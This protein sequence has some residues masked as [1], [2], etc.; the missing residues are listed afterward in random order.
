VKIQEILWIDGDRQLDY[1]E[2]Q[3]SEI[4]AQV[5]GRGIRVVL[6]V[7]QKTAKFLDSACVQIDS[8]MVIF[9]HRSP[10]VYADLELWIDANSNGA[11][12]LQELEIIAG[13]S[14]P[15]S[16]IEGNSSVF[17]ARLSQPQPL[18]RDLAPITAL[19]SPWVRLSQSPLSGFPLI[20]GMERG[21]LLAYVKSRGYGEGLWT[22]ELGHAV[23]FCWG[24]LLCRF[25][26]SWFTPAFSENATWNP[27]IDEISGVLAINRASL[28]ITELYDAEL[29][30]RIGSTGRFTAIAK[31][32]D[33]LIPVRTDAVNELRDA[34]RQLF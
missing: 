11:D 23:E 34:V 5:S 31:L 7:V 9:G 10:D 32:N 14:G 8:F 1:N 21:R 16:Q 18:E 25:G 24:S 6:P 33:R 30:M 29:V 19:S 20:S 15:E 13:L 26:N 12:Q 28:R 3:L 17:R 27:V 2:R 22:N 4:F